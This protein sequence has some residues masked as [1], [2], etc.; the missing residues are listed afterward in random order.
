MILELNLYLLSFH[1]I[2]EIPDILAHLR[3]LSKRKNKTVQN[4]NYRSSEI[5]VQNKI[6]LDRRQLI[7]RILKYII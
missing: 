5:S 4:Y 2:V 1:T 3:K 6:K 7:V